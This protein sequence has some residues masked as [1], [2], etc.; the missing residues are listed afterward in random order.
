MSIL[1]SWIGTPFAVALGWALL[2]FIW[3]GLA[4]ALLLAA[5]VWLTTSARW[6]YVAACAVLLAMPVAFGVTLAIEVAAHGGAVSVPGRVIGRQ[7]STGNGLPLAEAAGDGPQIWPSAPQAWLAPCWFLGVLFFYGRGMAG[8]IGVRRLRRRGVCAAPGEW[9]ERL[10]GLCASLRVT[11]P[12]V[13][14]ESCFAE[15]PALIGYLRP[16]ILMPMGCFTG[17]SA[18]QLECILIHELAHIRRHDYLVNLAQTLVEGLLFYHPAV[19]WASRVV[20]AERENCCDDVVVEIAGDARAYAATLAV[21]EQKRATAFEA[22]LAATGGS[23]MK[24]IRRLLQEPEAAR[25]SAA[26]AVVSGVLLVAVAVALAAWPAK[27]NAKPVPAPSAVPQAAGLPPQVT[28][29]QPP[30]WSAYVVQVRGKREPLPLL[31]LQSDPRPRTDAERRAQEQAPRQELATPYR[32]WLNED[33]AYIVTNQERAAFL[34][35]QTDEEREQFIEQFWLRRDPTPGT[36]ENEF[37]E[38]H[39]R[40]I[41][42]ANEH[43]ATLI[44][45]WKTDRGRIYITYGPPDEIDDHSSGGSY[46]RPA[47]QGGGTTSTFP[48]QQWRYR[49]IEGIG[50]NVIVEFV[51]PTMS[52][53]FHMT[54]DPNEKDALLLVRPP[55]TPYVV[56]PEDVLAI[57]VS[58]DARFNGSYVVLPNGSISLPL[59]GSIVAAGLTLPQIETAINN[60]LETLLK[61]AHASVRVELAHG[62]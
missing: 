26:P 45:G 40:R 50:A 52:G 36:T 49:F 3:E 47:E 62:K 21:L 10:A 20:R 48:F 25:S 32:K 34:A 16:A 39:Y 14:L 43:F 53:E 5:T 15:A 30:D 33:V 18:G 12:V 44:P 35:L 55:A 37:K 61:Q 1:E 6:R 60:A 31:A 38:E 9:Q 46:Q 56:H 2:H 28:Q 7:S 4:L 42:F 27:T 41:A 11:R 59:Y 17:L 13:L 58:E 54:M 19:W 51:D 8:W 29:P 57:R 22:A 24:R 23:L